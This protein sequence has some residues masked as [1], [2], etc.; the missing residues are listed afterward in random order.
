MTGQPGDAR[1]VVHLS[2]MMLMICREVMV[3]F[4]AYRTVYE[5]PVLKIESRPTKELANLDLRDTICTLGGRKRHYIPR[6][7]CSEQLLVLCSQRSA[8]ITQHILFYVIIPHVVKT[9]RQ[10]KR[11]MPHENTQ[12]A[13]HNKHGSRAHRI[14]KWGLRR[15]LSCSRTTL[16]H[17]AL[18]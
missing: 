3:V 15:S 11:R 7:R 10:N 1:H 8:T 5:A 12:L 6:T 17:A 14:G 4:I 18:P 9:D 13:P 16:K 2:D